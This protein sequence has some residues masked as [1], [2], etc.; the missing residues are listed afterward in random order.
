MCVH[1]QILT[2]EDLQVM[3][4][5]ITLLSS[6]KAK[7]VLYSFCVPEEAFSESLMHAWMNERMRTRELKSKKNQ[8]INV[9][10]H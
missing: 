4:T 9:K 7:T 1:T 10:K 2:V 8:N 5:K 3:E 6:L